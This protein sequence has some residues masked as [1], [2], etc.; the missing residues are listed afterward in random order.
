M[1][2]ASGVTPFRKKRHWFRW[3]VLVLLFALAIVLIFLLLNP[4]MIFQAQIDFRVN[5]SLNPFPNSQLIY[6]GHPS[7]DAAH[8]R[9][10]IYWTD[11]EYQAVRGHDFII[12]YRDH[13]CQAMLI[14]EH[15]GDCYIVSD[16]PQATLDA[17]LFFRHDLCCYGSDPYQLSLV[18]V[19]IVSAE[20]IEN[21]PPVLIAYSEYEIDFAELLTIV[22][23]NG[24]FILIGYRG[25]F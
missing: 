15:L 19:H 20:N 13:F 11:A 16:L 8:V 21:L 1:V 9:L 22:P 23:S 4:R 5:Q 18:N 17:I 10:L 7:S 6:N 25:G 14:S 12:N 24:T 3:A 2:G